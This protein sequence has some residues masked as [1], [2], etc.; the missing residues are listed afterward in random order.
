MT[1]ETKIGLLVGLAFIIVVAILLSD[2]VNNANEPQAAIN[3]TASTVRQSLTIPAPTAPVIDRTTVITPNRAPSREPILTQTEAADQTARDEVKVG[4]GSAPLKPIVPSTPSSD[5]QQVAMQGGT[6][7]QENAVVTPVAPPAPSIPEDLRHVAAKAGEPLV[8][9]SSHEPTSTDPETTAIPAAK[10]RYTAEAGDSVSKMAGRLMGANTRANRAAI[11]AAN[12][13]LQKDPNRVIVGET[14]T[15][16]GVATAAA[17]APASSDVDAQTPAPTEVA[18]APA[19]KQSTRWY[20]VKPNDSL[21]RIATN[22]VG[23]SAAVSEIMS[24]NKDILKG[25]STLQADM[26]LR[27]PPK[28]VAS[29]D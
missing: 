13:S 20:T 3:D 14:Y 17:P 18:V 9:T 27:L 8:S 19:G 16:P 21:W 12:P 11:I 22:E 6:S 10:Q 5:N 28:T 25:K 29:A 1:R 24:L 4:P 15:I 2:P 23:D 26:R 7:G